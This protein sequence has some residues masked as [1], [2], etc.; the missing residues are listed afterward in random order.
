VDVFGSGSR[1][2]PSI[3]ATGVAFAAWCLA[4]AAVNAW[5]LATGRLPGD[6]V[7]AYATVFVVESV[8][9]L[10]IK[11]VAAGVALCS[12]RS[13]PRAGARALLGAAL[14]GA[15]STLG[16]Y[17]A[18]SLTIA[19]GTV[20][21]LVEPSAAWEAAGG[22]TPR[23]IAYVLF[24]LVGAGMAAALATSFHRR[25]RLGWKVVATGAA[26]APLLLGGLLVILPALL[27]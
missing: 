27:V 3:R 6:E 16:L 11:L 14:W 23:S 26:V 8:V 22:V 7:P 15:A 17:S 1:A 13:L 9:V 10:L 20:T 24:F 4:F 5:Q 25:H 12:L 19:I 2:S 18:G 21:G